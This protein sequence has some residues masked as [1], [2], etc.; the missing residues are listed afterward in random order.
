M[1]SQWKLSMCHELT[2]EVEMLNLNID[3]AFCNEYSAQQGI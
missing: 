3:N 1:S 2:M